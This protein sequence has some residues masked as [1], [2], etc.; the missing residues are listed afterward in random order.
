[1]KKID[2]SN[3]IIS[4]VKSNNFNNNVSLLHLMG[5]DQKGYSTIKCI[6]S[7]DVGY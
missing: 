3:I 7:E 6:P 4:D 5:Q 1:M 2:E